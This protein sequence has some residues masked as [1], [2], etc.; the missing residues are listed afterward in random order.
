MGLL[1]NARLAKL[2]TSYAN[3]VKSSFACCVRLCNWP[4]NSSVKCAS[5]KR[6]FSA[7]VILS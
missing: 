3:V 4:C 1:T 7:D 6:N 5:P 2:W